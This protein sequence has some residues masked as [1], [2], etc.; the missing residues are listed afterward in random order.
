MLHAQML[1]ANRQPTACN[2]SSALSHESALPTFGTNEHL[3]VFMVLMPVL[4]WHPQVSR[5]TQRPASDSRKKAPAACLNNEYPGRS[6]YCFLL[7]SA[8]ASLPQM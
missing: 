1:Y 3:Q 2:M 6:K 5:A 4:C 8:G 7:A